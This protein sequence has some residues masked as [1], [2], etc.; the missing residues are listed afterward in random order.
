[1]KPQNIA[2]LL[3]DK[4]LE[5]IESILKNSDFF[6]EIIKNLKTTADILIT[7]YSYLDEIF[8]LESQKIKK[9]IC[10]IPKHYLEFIADNFK[11]KKIIFLELPITYKKLLDSIK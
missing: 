1:M 5:I 9:I 11:N 6:Y 8:N 4:N 3:S 10:I 7:E 2:L